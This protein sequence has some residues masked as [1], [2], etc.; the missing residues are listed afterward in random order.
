[1][2]NSITF[3]IKSKTCTFGVCL[4]LF[5]MFSC[6][7]E[8]SLIYNSPAV[9]RNNSNKELETEYL[10]N[11]REAATYLDSILIV[12]ERNKKKQFYSIA[13]KNF[14]LAEPVLAFVDQNNYKSL[15]APNILSVSETDLTDINVVKPFGFQ[16]IEELVYEDSVDLNALKTAVD[17]TSSRLK[18]IEKNTNLKFKKHHIMWLIRNEIVRIASAGITGFDSPVLNQS[19]IETQ[20][21]YNTLEKIIELYKNNF[22]SEDL[23]KQ[24]DASFTKALKALKHDFDSFDRYAFI[25][26]HIHPQLKLLLKVQNDW[27]VSYPF[28]LALSNNLSSL[29]SKNTLNVYYFSD[30]KSDTTNI[31][32]KI[33]LGKSLFNDKVLSKN[34]DMACVTCHIKNKAF[35]DGKRV[36]DPR[37]TRNTPTLTYAAY[38]QSFFMDSRSGS[39]EGQVV[40]VVENH[41]EFAMT[42]D[43]IVERV[44][45]SEKYKNTMDSLYTGKRK[46]YHIRHAIAS[47]IRDLNKFNSKFDRNIRGEENTLITSEKNGFNLFMGKALCGTCHFAPVFNGTV[48]PNFSDTELEAIGVPQNKDTINAQISIDLGRYNQ[49]KT[50]ERKHFFK[51]PTIRNAALTAPYMHN[52]VYNTLEEVVDFY[53]KGGGQGVGINLPNQTLPFDNLNLTKSEQK[54]VV[55]FIK[56]L[57]DTDFLTD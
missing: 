7:K 9:N 28:E 47:Y 42:M 21:T 52:G 34:Y 11:L 36:F 39:L 5:F 18:L 10:K 54:D 55:A 27:G 45:K 50:P 20:Y 24:L 14:K 43:A 22:T 33:A 25:K 37:Q 3:A 31:A 48:P 29:F 2:K 30:F 40:G 8:N 35:T 57:T 15:N 13:R 53:N 38:Q 51:T 23:Y 32:K 26:E 56:T 6:K 12:T 4:L 1:M 46:G 16:V 41:N 19:L 17:K 49:F 44:T